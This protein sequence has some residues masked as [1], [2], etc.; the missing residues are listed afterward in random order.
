MF[1]TTLL[2][3]LRGR[4]ATLKRVCLLVDARHGFKF[5]DV[6]F[7][8]RLY[9]RRGEEGGGHNPLGP[10]KPPKLQVNSSSCSTSDTL[11]QLTCVVVCLKKC[12][13]AHIASTD[14]RNHKLRGQA[15][16]QSV[17]YH[18]NTEWRWCSYTMSLTQAHVLQ[19]SV[20]TQLLCIAAMLR[21]KST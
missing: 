20:K 12:T 17:C 9:A 5:N 3:Y 13:S 21:A 11:L 16:K 8:E 10:Y 18:C 15:C 1:L 19:R 14:R 6:K 2:V 7:M 4:G